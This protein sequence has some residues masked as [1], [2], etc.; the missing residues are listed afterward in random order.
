MIRQTYELPTQM[1]ASV[2]WKTGAYLISPISSKLQLSYVW[3]CCVHGASVLRS[4]NVTLV[5]CNSE[6]EMAY[7]RR[8]E[9]GSRLF[10]V[11]SVRKVSV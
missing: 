3:T 8:A 1:G 4:P 9:K 7:Q 2:G 5:V 11:N 6:L 10:A